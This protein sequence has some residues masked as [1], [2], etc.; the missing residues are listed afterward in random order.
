MPCAGSRMGGD[1][2]VDR[3]ASVQSAGEEAVPPLRIVSSSNFLRGYGG[4]LYLA[5]ALHER[6]ASVRVLAPIPAAQLAEVKELPFPVETMWRPGMPRWAALRLF[7]LRLLALGL[8]RAGG[9]LFT[10]LSFFREAVAIRRARPANRLVH[11]C[12]ELFTPEEFPSIPHVRYYERHA[13]VPDLVIDVEAA[14]AERRWQRFGLPCRPLILPNTLPHAS[15]PPPAPRGSLAALAGGGLPQGVPTLLYAGGTHAGTA[16]DRVVAALE[17]LG[18][19]VFFLAFCHDEDQ[20]RFRAFQ[21]LVAERLG[22]DRARVCPAVPRA[23]L[24]ACAHEAR[25]GLV[26]Y[27]FDALPSFNQRHCAPA[28]VYELLA[29]GV[30][31]VTSANPP[32]QALVGGRGLGVCAADDSVPALRAAIRT[33]LDDPGN[34]T[35]AARARAVFEQELCFERVAP[36]VVDAVCEVLRGSQ[37]GL[38]PA[39]QGAGAS[40]R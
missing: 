32:L 25:A 15:L 11:Y 29:L 8:S 39:T 37:R 23:R 35:M 17:G 24:L 10:D 36:G 18:V 16:L 19:P 4:I 13:S 22:P 14:R 20:A 40:P 7:R 21:A 33:V 6:G 27:P 38:P 2:A 26:Y 3:N 9:W 28:K 12:A 31:P 34:R 30:P 1:T 5:Q